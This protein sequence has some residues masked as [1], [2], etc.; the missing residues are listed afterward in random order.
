VQPEDLIGAHDGGVFVLVVD[1]VEAGAHIFK[2]V[3][4]VG[5]GFAV[6]AHA[7]ANAHLEILR[8]VCG[9]GGQAAVGERIPRHGGA[10]CGGLL[11][12][13]VV[14]VDE[15]AEDELVVEKATIHHPAEFGAL[16][17]LVVGRFDV[18]GLIAEMELF[19]HGCFHDGLLVGVVEG[20]HA[21]DHD[22][23]EVWIGRLGGR[24]V[25][26]CFKAGASL[27]DCDGRRHAIRRVA[28]DET[29]AGVGCAAELGFLELIVEFG[30]FGAS[31]VGE[32][33]DGGD[34]VFEVVE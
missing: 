7:N 20:G 22:A 18:V 1:G 12:D 9:S 25:E 17:A 3:G 10:G 15:V 6:D 24:P 30:G 11:Q 21:A 19:H 31:A 8:D 4:E 14:G 32:V 2:G 23:E 27:L 5:A 16:L 13:E 28:V 26:E 33:V 34:T 29:D